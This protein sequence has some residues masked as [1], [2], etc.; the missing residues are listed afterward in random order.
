MI[1]MNKFFLV[2]SVK[3]K[4]IFRKTKMRQIEP[5]VIDDAMLRTAVQDQ[6]PVGEAGKIAKKEEI[7]YKTVETLRLDSLNILKIENLWQ[8]TSLTKLQMDSNMIEKIDG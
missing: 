8:F 7:P 6:G 5:A 1:D 4:I 3:A 2:N